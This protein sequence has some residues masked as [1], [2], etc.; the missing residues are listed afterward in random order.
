MVEESAVT[1]SLLFAVTVILMFHVILPLVSLT[2][3]YSVSRH[4][5][6]FVVQNHC[7]TLLIL[8]FLLWQKLMKKQTQ[9]TIAAKLYLL[10]YYR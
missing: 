8:L 5:I 7:S 2:K 3:Y 10:R 1:L 4:V 9:L 6:Q